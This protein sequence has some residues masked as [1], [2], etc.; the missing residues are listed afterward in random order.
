LSLR[1]EQVPLIRPEVWYLAGEIDMRRTEHRK[2]IQALV[3]EMMAY[4]RP[5]LDE[6]QRRVLD[7]MTVDDLTRPGSHR[8]KGE[9]SA[10]TAP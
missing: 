10:Q 6:R 8:L 7:N 9:P 4:I 3:D 1:P 2:D 5:M